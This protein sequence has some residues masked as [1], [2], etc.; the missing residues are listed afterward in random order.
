MDRAV[1]SFAQSWPARSKQTRPFIPGVSAEIGK[2]GSKRSGDLLGSRFEFP[3]HRPSRPQFLLQFSR[4]LAEP[5]Q[6]QLPKSLPGK[7]RMRYTV[8]D[9]THDAVVERPVGG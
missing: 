2:Q 1:F 9:L 3:A 7:T 4:T 8:Q 6:I 5:L